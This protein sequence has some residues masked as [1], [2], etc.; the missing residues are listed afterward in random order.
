MDLNSTVITLIPKWIVCGA[1]LRDRGEKIISRW[2]EDSCQGSSPVHSIPTYATRLF[3]HPKGLTAEIQRLSVRF[4]WW[5]N[6]NKRKIHW[7][8]WKN[9]CKVKTD[10]GLG[11]Y[12]LE[13]FNRSLLAKQGWRIIK[14]LDSLTSRT[15]KGCYFPNSSLLAAGKT[16]VG[17]F[18][19]NSLIWGK[20]ILD[21]G[22]RW[23][24]G[25]GTS[26]RIY[27]DKWVSRP[28]TF[29]ILS[30]PSLGVDTA[31]DRLLSPSGGWDMQVL[32][33]NF[34]VCDIDAMLEIPSRG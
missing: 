20:G 13:N 1:I 3:Q 26:I 6:E 9:L 23:R 31:V 22:L 29:K 25:N 32:K 18:I 4:W 15:L 28:N 12:D 10:G 14:N 16:C 21:K 7:G 11:F 8:T 19:W 33:Q 34:L 30:P 5:G 17:S 27:K 2:Q 24:L